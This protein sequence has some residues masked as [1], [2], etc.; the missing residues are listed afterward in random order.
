MVSPARATATAFPK[1]AYGLSNDP[2]PLVSSPAIP[3][4]IPSALNLV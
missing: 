4:V 1:V 3:A 2:S